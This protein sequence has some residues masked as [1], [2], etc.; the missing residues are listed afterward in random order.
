MMATPKFDS[1][2]LFRYA[3]GELDDSTRAFIRGH[4]ERS[5]QLRERVAYWQR[6]INTMRTDDS[7]APPAE[8]LA[9]AKALYQPPPTANWLT[10]IA[11]LPRAIA[12]VVFD[13]RTAGPVPGLRGA[14]DT[15]ELSFTTAH[16]EIDLE[17]VPPEAG[18][19]EWTL[20]GQVTTRGTATE[21]RNAAS[22]LLVRNEVPVADAHCDETGM[23]RLQ[24][25]PGNYALYVNMHN[26]VIELPPI[27]IPQE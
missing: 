13:S 10:Q 8:L 4:L 14:S 21:L 25:R 18:A 6:I 23:F 9:R 7:E 24:T 19:T 11:D 16:A 17:L 26:Q 1:D 22:V 20:L 15:V 2:T 27:T 3:A 12:R 5:P